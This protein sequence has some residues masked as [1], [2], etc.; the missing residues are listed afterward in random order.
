MFI[1]KEE[2]LSRR[3]APLRPSLRGG[4]AD[5]RR[6]Y[7]SWH[8]AVRTILYV[9][10]G[11]I[12]ALAALA[13]A[14]LLLAPADNGPPAQAPARPPDAA[15]QGSPPSAPSAAAEAPAA[16]QTGLTPAGPLATPP[17]E[18][19]TTATGPLATPPPE[20]GTTATGPLTTPPPEA[21]TTA[22]GPM[23]TPPSEAG[24]TPSGLVATP[25]PGLSADPRVA[26]LQSQLDAATAALADLRSEAAHM[27]SRMAALPPPPAARSEAPA[28]PGARP[29]KPPPGVTA[30]AAGAPPPAETAAAWQD[31]E[32]VVSALH[33]APAP[34]S[35]P[36]QPASQP[37]AQS[38]PVQAGTAPVA[39]APTPLSGTAA[40]PSVVASVAVSPVRV[41]LYYRGG[42]SD[43]LT[44]VADL[45]RR[46]VDSDFA[47]GDTRSSAYRPRQSVIRYFFPQ[48]AAAAQRLAN[49]FAPA[50]LDFK[51]QDDTDH[52]GKATPGTLDAWVAR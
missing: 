36:A 39:S 18:A 35:Q 26:E 32:R 25:P 41:F 50:G 48:D 47:Y 24:T 15:L 13:V 42:S 16:A 14:A 20:A 44:A 3:T 7:S 10:M 46:L 52:P 1:E 22:T 11:S 33:R 43:G 8:S 17:P 19:G 4:A 21:G 34:T 5:G 38:P 28:V 23:P 40:V 30:P 49:L 51:V 45:A 37:A 27:R 31:A 2:R 6:G 9:C 12:A 29:T